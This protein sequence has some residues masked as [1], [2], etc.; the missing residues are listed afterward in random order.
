MESSLEDLNNNYLAGTDNC[1]SDVDST[2]TLLSHYQ[3]FQSNGGCTAIRWTV[4]VVEGSR[5]ILLSTRRKISRKISR[6]LGSSAG[7]VVS[8]A[9]WLKIAAQAIQTCRLI[10]WMRMA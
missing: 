7:H 8:M 1:P 2:V 5:K 3:D 9:T 6:S 10:T 4:M